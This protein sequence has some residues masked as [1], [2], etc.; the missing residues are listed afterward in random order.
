MVIGGRGTQATGGGKAVQAVSRAARCMAVPLL[1]AGCSSASQSS[2]NPVNWWHHLEGGEIA[3]QRPP[4]PGSN[5]PYPNLATVPPRPATPDKKQLELITQGLVADRAHAEYMT[6]AAP[7]AD[8]SS[9]QAS[10]GL[11]GTGSMP[12]PPPPGAPTSAPTASA[13]L[14]AASGP[15]TQPATQPPKPSPAP[16][17]A[18]Q[19]AALSPPAAAPP[20]A[21]GAATAPAAGSA[22]VPPS[23]PAAGTARP[24][25][26]VA[27]TAA[28]NVPPPPTPAIPDAPPPP[29]NVPGA[30]PMA[31]AAATP[32]ATPATQ[33]PGEVRIEFVAGSSELPPGANDILKELVAQR[34]SAAIALTGHGDAT[35]EDP[36]IQSAALSLALARAQA[37]AKALVADGVPESSI[38]VGAEASGRGAVARLIQ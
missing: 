20:P 24:G 4:P 8:P 34:G 9:P 15:P 17:G 18:V 1:L 10:P 37:T 19:S 25:A 21:V 7:I 28:A 32:P 5:Q 14:S 33:R 27:A 16:R 29:P 31:V 35:S 30:P 38:R 6:A 26:P 36:A 22:N 12:P 2:I 3:K 11:F 13:S 23:G